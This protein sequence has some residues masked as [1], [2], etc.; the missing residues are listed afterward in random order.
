MSSR[1]SR[2]SAF[3]Y[4][5]ATQRLKLSTWKQYEGANRTSFSLATRPSANSTMNGPVS[6]HCEFITSVSSFSTRSASTATASTSQVRTGRHHCTRARKVA[7]VAHRKKEE[8]MGLLDGRVA[9]V[10]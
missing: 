8:N 1:T 5:A 10:T 4:T 2:G 3:A 7:T 6:N 9:V